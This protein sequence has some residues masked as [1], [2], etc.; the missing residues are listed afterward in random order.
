MRGARWAPGGRPLAGLAVAV[1]FGLALAGLADSVGDGPG[2]LATASLAAPDLG[3]GSGN[4]AFLPLIRRDPVA[5]PCPSIPG[6]SYGAISVSSTYGATTNAES[7]PDINLAVRGWQVNSTAPKVLVDYG[8]GGSDPNAPQLAGLFASNRRPVFTT[9]YQVYDWNWTTNQRGGLLTKWPVTL[10]GLASTPGEQV[11]VPSA[12]YSIGLS[13]MDGYQ[14]LVLYA[15]PERITLKYTRED[16][17]VAGYTLHVENVCVDPSLVSLYQSLNT[18]GRN[19]L[20]ALNAG[21]AFGTARGGELAVAIRDTG[22]FM[23]PRSR[24]DWWHGW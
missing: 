10:A 24:L 1:L 12:G 15:T 17:V 18:A 8:N 11:R 6:A 21:Q 4:R 16:N 2:E 22:E 23:D 19:P 13:I 3:P 7:H 14:V 20:P 9:L 5:T